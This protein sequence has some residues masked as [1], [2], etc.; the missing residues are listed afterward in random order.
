MFDL[1][2]PFLRPDLRPERV[3]R[4]TAVKAGRRPPLEAAQSGLDR[5]EHGATLPREGPIIQFGEDR[6][7]DALAARLLAG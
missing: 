6:G 2:G 1:R 5:G 7:P 3:P 4:A